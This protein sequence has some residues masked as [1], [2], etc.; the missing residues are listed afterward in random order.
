MNHAKKKKNGVPDKASGTPLHSV[1]G[2]LC[3][4]RKSAELYSPKKFPK[5]KENTRNPKISGVFLELL[6]GFEPPTSSLPSAVGYAPSGE[7][8]L[9]IENTVHFR[10][11]KT[12]TT[13]GCT[14]CT[15][16]LMHFHHTPK[17]T[18]KQGKLHQLSNNSHYRSKQ[19][20]N[21]PLTSFL[22]L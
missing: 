5:A 15:A 19:D 21:S 17:A 7:K 18:Q 6:G 20:Q 4:Q 14:I 11:L 3:G 10:V 22:Q 8:S 16:S 1:C 13:S 12:E 2:I 9:S